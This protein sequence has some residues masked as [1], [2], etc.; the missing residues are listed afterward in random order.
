[1]TSKE[2]F[3]DSQVLKENAFLQRFFGENLD[4][5]IYPVAH[6]TTVW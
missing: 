1:M 3:K 2:A 5:Y 4:S 6:R